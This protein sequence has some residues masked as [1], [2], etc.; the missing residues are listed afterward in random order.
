MSHTLALNADPIVCHC[1]QVRASRVAD[2]VELY[3]LDTVPEI[4]AHCGAGGGC[5][6]C[7]R[8]IRDLIA[9]HRQTPAEPV[10]SLPQR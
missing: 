5:T 2:C 8:R 1:L 10:G 9:A 7:H 4:K 3:G 6:A